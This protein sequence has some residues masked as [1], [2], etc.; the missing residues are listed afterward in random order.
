VARDA[1]GARPTNR[2]PE[3]GDGPT[4]GMSEFATELEIPVR[5]RDIDAEG[6][7]N[8]AVYL[9]YI[10]QARVRYIGDVL[11]RSPADP[12]FVV[13]HVS[14][15]YERSI[16]LEKHLAG[17]PVVVAMGTTAVGDSSITMEYELRASGGRAATAETVIV[18][19]DEAGQP[20]AVP[21]DWREALE[22]HEGR[23]F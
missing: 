10:E 5:Y 9:S 7:V 17:T 19:V 13:A 11:D 16:D 15:D 22:T 4:P 18:A 1:V 8:N 23:T 6:H 21:D 14:I 3:T 12:G 20:R 2:Q